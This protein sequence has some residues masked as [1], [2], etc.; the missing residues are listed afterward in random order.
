M[1]WTYY[2]DKSNS[3]CN[4]VSEYVKFSPNLDQPMSIFFLA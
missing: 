2:E 4:V 1:H 3:L